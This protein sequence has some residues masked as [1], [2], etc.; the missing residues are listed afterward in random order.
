MFLWPYRQ[1]APPRVVPGI[2]LYG[3]RTFLSLPGKLRPSD[4]PLSI[5][6]PECEKVVNQSDW[7]R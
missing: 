3:V 1:I 6:I 7:M 5:I 2:A 4:Q